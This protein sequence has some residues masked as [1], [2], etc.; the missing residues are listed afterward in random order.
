[1]NLHK[2]SQKFTNDTEIYFIFLTKKRKKKTDNL[3]VAYVAKKIRFL[4]KTVHVES[5]CVCGPF[6]KLL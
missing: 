1:M 3:H 2:T 5:V 4:S 6:M